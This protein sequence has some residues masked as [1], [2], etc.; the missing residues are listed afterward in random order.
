MRTKVTCKAKIGDKYHKLT[1]L[2]LV[3]RTKERYAHLICQCECG[4]IK[5]IE[6][7]SVRSGNTRSCGCIGTGIEK[8]RLTH[9][10]SNTPLHGIWK[11]MRRR[12]NNPND[13]H[14]QNYGGRGIKVCERWDDFMKFL[15]DM[16]PRPKGL[17]LE[18][19]DSN[20]NYEPANCYWAT[21]LSQA[22]N[23]RRTIRITHNGVSL[24]IRGWA[25]ATG[26]AHKLIY[27]RYMAG[28]PIHEVLS[29]KLFSMIRHGR[30]TVVRRTPGVQIY[31]PT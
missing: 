20:S 10:M 13:S 29:K 17:T 24:T 18:R 15:Q 30:K 27:K 6:S 12:C 19:R 2:E 23:T 7:Q 5:S 3:P 16:G 8:V 26:V 11:A 25:D 21:P 22:N 9:G 14:Y 31:T 4:K 28:W 1:I